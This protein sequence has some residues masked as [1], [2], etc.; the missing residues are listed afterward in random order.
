ME[1]DTVTASLNA[2]KGDLM[3]IITGSRKSTGSDLNNVQKDK[4]KR[5][6]K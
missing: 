2:E 5:K 1:S 3:G 4:V 6:K